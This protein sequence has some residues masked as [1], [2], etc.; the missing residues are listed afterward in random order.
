MPVGETILYFGCYHEDSDFLYGD[1]LKEFHKKG[2]IELHTAYSHDQLKLIFVQD[3][4]LEN[5]EKL[6]L[7]FF[8]FII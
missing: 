3:K 8:N 6:N 5:S 2:V 4:M 7:L 1:E